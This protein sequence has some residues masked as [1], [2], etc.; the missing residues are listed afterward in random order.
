MNKGKVILYAVLW[1]IMLAPIGVIMTGIDAL[2]KPATLAGVGPLGPAS[3]EV[4]SAIALPIY[5]AVKTFG[6]ALLVLIVLKAACIRFLA[7][8]PW[9]ESIKY[10]I[11]LI[12]AISGIGFYGA[13]TLY[14]DTIIF[15]FPILS[16][17]PFILAAKKK[18][19][20]WM[21][22]AGFICTWAGLIGA[23]IAG[24][25]NSALPVSSN[26]L[27]AFSSP[28]FYFGL[29][30]GWEPSISGHSLKTGFPTWH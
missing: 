25:H 19:L 28:L 8:T 4:V 12:L 27:R 13:G 17:I 14:S 6:V 23:F 22:I 5:V 30:L 3:P 1:A 7:N 16:I 11:W 29:T 26:L 21:A 10:S 9:S 24:T 20:W 18:L 15:I 2:A